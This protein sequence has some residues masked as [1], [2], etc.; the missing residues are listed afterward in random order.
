[1]ESENAAGVISPDHHKIDLPAGDATGTTM[2]KKHIL[3]AGS[4]KA[5]HFYITLRDPR[6]QK[7]QAVGLS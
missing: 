2:R 7:L 5:G 4:T 1:M 3:I 6:L